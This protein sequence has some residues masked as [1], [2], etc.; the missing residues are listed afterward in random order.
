MQRLILLLGLLI[1]LSSQV[2]A[3][4]VN[5][6]PAPTQKPLSNELSLPDKQEMQ[7]QILDDLLLKYTQN[8]T[9][10]KLHE[11]MVLK[12]QQLA[13]RGT[14]R[15]P[16]Q[17]IKEAFQRTRAVYEKTKPFVHNTF[18]DFDPDAV[19][20]SVEKYLWLKGLCFWILG[21]NQEHEI[22]LSYFYLPENQGVKKELLRD[23]VHYSFP[24]VP[25]IPANR[26]WFQ[27]MVQVM[28][29]LGYKI[30]NIE[31]YNNPKNIAAAP[32][33]IS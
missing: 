15:P 19:E 25:D 18:Q 23:I 13:K 27:N 22:G 9:F 4:A 2:A 29:R 21:I 6:D 33:G 12:Y 32:G 24:E 17:I 30:F 28:D 31:K 5:P 11:Y 14:P 1:L 10:V 7:Q 8:Q 3:A 16:Q 26:I 20:R